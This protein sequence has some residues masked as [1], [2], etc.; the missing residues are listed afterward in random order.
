VTLAKPSTCRRWQEFDEN[1]CTMK[2]TQT[3]PQPLRHAN[4]ISVA[5]WIAAIGTWAT[6]YS[7]IKGLQ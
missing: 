4:V 7:L 2:Q 1:H 3:K 5:I 6:L